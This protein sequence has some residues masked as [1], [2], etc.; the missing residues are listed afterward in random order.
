M[1]E[2]TG[3]GRS[4]AAGIRAQR[5]R[6]SYRFGPDSGDESSTA[7]NTRTPVSAAFVQHA[8]PITASTDLELGMVGAIAAGDLHLSP[9]AQLR[10]TPARELSVSGSYARLHQ[11]AQSLRNSESVVGNIFP[12]DLYVGAGSAEVPVARSDQGIVALEYRPAAG[13][14]F[15]VQAYER[16]FDGLVLVAPQDGD[17]FATSGFVE[18][19]GGAR[20]VSFE[21]GAN[22]AR[23]GIIASYGLQRVRLEYGDTSYVPDYGATHSIEAGVT[24]FPSATSS[25]R[26]GATGVLGRRT[27]P[28]AGLVEWEACNLLDQGC[29]F[30]GSPQHPL[31]SLGA[32]RLP[33]YFRVDLGIAKHWHLKLADRD[34]LVS[35]FGTVT[36]IFGRS[37]V[38][39]IAANPVTGELAE[40][41]MRPLSPLVLGI[42]WRF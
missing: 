3:K 5:S 36:N 40:L 31:D 41:T 18:G 23:Y 1:V 27:T 39:T 37:N 13:V 15:G 10:W 16:D 9:R 21:A 30:S 4:T 14:R 24:I 7:L 26:L 8:R 12:A 34:G 6:T 33:A 35:L 38:L 17:P 28:I 22:G 2:M 20:G 29:E 11:F 19:S 25:V 32:T 42:D